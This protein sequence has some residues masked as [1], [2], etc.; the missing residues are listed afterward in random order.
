MSEMGMFRQF[1][2]VPNDWTRD[3]RNLVPYAS[4]VT[5]YAEVPY[6][7]PLSEITVAKPLHPELYR[8]PLDQC[9]VIVTGTRTRSRS[10]DESLKRVKYR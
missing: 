9:A 7:R 4:R 2:D 10:K 6:F 8:D 3:D 5:L 1:Q